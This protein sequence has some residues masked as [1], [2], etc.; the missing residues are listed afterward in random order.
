VKSKQSVPAPACELYVSTLFRGRRRHVEASC[1]QWFILSAKH[2]LVE[3]SERIEPYDLTLDDLS[4]AQRAAWSTHVLDSLNDRVGSLAGMVVE[5]HA[6]STYRDSGLVEGLRSAEAIVEVPAEGLNQGQQLAYYQGGERPTPARRR[7]GGRYSSLQALLEQEPDDEVTLAFDEIEEILGSSLP[8]SARTYREWWSNSSRSPQGYSW[9]SAGWRVAEVDREQAR[10]RFARLD[11]QPA[12]T[13][14]DDQHERGPVDA[15][16][17]VR[18]K[19]ADPGRAR[20]I[21]VLDRKALTSAGL[22]SWWADE[23]AREVIGLAL[24]TEIPPLIYVGQAGATKR[25]SGTPSQATLGSRIAGQHA[26]GNI[27]SS[28]FRLTISAIL[29]D[30][31]DL[32][33]DATGSLRADS[34]ATV[35]NWIREHLRVA[36]VDVED[37]DTLGALEAEIVGAIDPPLNLDHVPA[38]PSR[39]RLKELRSNLRARVLAVPQPS[40]PTIEPA[41]MAPA[42]DWLLRIEPVDLS[43]TSA[44]RPSPAAVTA[45][46]RLAEQLPA[47]RQALTHAPQGPAS[48]I[49]VVFSPTVQRALE[50]GSLDLMSSGA[51]KLS[52]AVNTAGRIVEIGRVAPTGLGAVGVA[53]I[54]TPPLWPVVVAGGLALAAAYAEQ[55][56]LEQT[57]GELRHAMERLEH[58]MRDDDAGALASA[59]ALVSLLAP[60]GQVAAVPEQLRIELALA[61]R[62][63]DAVYLARRRFVDRF[64]RALEAAQDEH[65][66]RTGQRTAWVGK[67]TDELAD[68]RTGV[69]DE[70]VLFLQAMIARAR[71]AA[72]TA[73]VLAAEGGSEHAVRLL[74]TI[75]NEMRTDYFDLHNR[76]AALARGERAENAWGRLR[77]VAGKRL[78]MLAGGTDDE[79]IEVVRSIERAMRETVGAAMPERDRM[80]DLVVPVDAVRALERG[81]PDS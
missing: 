34:N 51:E 11:G 40:A 4:T 70:L 47:I 31:L 68:R 48:G 18:A 6:G 2:G 79:G 71:L 67:V 3:P 19:L 23:D 52:V 25:P 38:T 14:Y 56:W 65:E 1:D 30:A 28:T 49:R 33:C 57:F 10:V 35:T 58:R 69:V 72:I 43:T 45:V 15:V 44:R 26:G 21:N 66:A 36:T 78:P 27:G 73:G 61:R 55:R 24:G 54:A 17:S 50:S 37:R 41:A 32:H 22:Y 64:K 8:A 75:E 12:K 46:A 74:A 7:G 76:I 20:P 63:V 13:Q 5:I 80:V 9:M 59:D 39:R 81:G 42:E 60:H 16:A 29:A 77:G 53:A 62:N